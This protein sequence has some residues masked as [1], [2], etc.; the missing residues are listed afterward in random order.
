MGAAERRKGARGE[1]EL[2]ALL[3]GATKVS[4]SGYSGHDV[5]WRGRSVEVK[6][7]ETVPVT[8][9]KWLADAQIVAMRRNRHPWLVCM[10]IDTLLDLLD[11]R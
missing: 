7:R 1:R 2:T 6:H 11:E 9:Y 3:P 10:E 8:P 4:R 5:E